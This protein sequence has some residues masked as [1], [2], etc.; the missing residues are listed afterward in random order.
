LSH[1]QPIKQTKLAIIVP[2]MLPVP[3]VRGG[4]VEHWVYEV[5]NRLNPQLF[6]ITVLS[7]PSDTAST[8]HVRYIGIP[9]TPLEKAC[10]WIKERMSWRN[11]I[12]YLAKIQNVLS[13]GLRLR[14]HLT[15]ADVVVIHNEPNLLM[16]LPKQAHQR[17]VLHM[18]NDHLTHPMFKWCYARVLQKVDQVI[19]VSS[20]IQQSAARAFPEHSDKFTVL[21]NATDTDVFQPYGEQAAIATS[22]LL[23]LPVNMPF[24]LYVGRLTQEKGVDVLIQAFQQTLLTHP[25]AKLV[26][27]GSSFFEGAATTRYQQKLIELAKP[28]AHHII[29]TGFIPH[30][31]LK[32]L[33]AGA[34][35]VVLPS[36]W[37]DPCPLV[38]LETMAS[39]TC[40]VASKVG[41]V[42]EVIDHEVNGVLVSPNQVDALT[43][44]LNDLLQYP[45]KAQQI[46]TAARQ[47][48]LDS[49]TWQHLV[50]QLEHML[51]Q[52]AYPLQ[53]TSVDSVNT[54]INLT[55]TL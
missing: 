31:Q 4:A 24:V 23:N 18:H 49:Y 14:D 36:V 5:V 21:F 50:A 20:Y 6:A 27:T 44:A 34:H 12:R 48:M 43:T 51:L 25:T 3:P 7:R 53:N 15:D 46:G 42:P 26:I 47:K 10:H 41:G 37:H 9:W 54:K 11:P 16:L 38:V 32:Y 28:I 13:Y 35:I 19:C 33:Y 40:I 39:G 30:A 22:T 55:E 45:D 52:T 2:E 8:N 1:T 29:F 17:W